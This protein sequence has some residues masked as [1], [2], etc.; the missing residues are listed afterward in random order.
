[1]WEVSAA[2]RERGEPI[3]LPHYEQPPVETLRH[4]LDR[5]AEEVYR[6]LPTDAHRNV[7]RLIFQQL[8]DRDAENREVRRPTPLSELTAV[9]VEAASRTDAPVDAGVVR[10]V[11]AAF[12]GKGRAF[13]VINAQQDVDI[14]HESFIRRWTRLR[15]WVLRESRSRRVYL[16]LADVAASWREGQASLYRGPELTEA[17]RWWKQETPTQ[18]WANRYD[19]RF[20]VARRFLEKSQRWR[21][22][23][24]AVVFGNVAV[25]L[26]GA[27]VIA[28]LMAKGRAEAQRAE[29]EAKRAEAAALQ[30]RNDTDVANRRLA[31][32]NQLIEQA[33]TLQKEGKSQQAAAL[34]QEAQQVQSTANTSTLTASE[35]S[36]L[37][38]LRRQ[39]ATWLKTEADLRGQ[40][41][42][43]R[44][45][46]NAAPPVAAAPNPEAAPPSKA[47][48]AGSER[49]ELEKLR[50]ARA[51]W[52]RETAQL[53]QQLTSANDRAKILQQSE[54]SL[55]RV[56]ENLQARLDKGD[57]GEGR[58]SDRTAIEQ[59]LRDFEAAYRNRDVNA[60]VKLMPS[61]KRADLTRTFSQVRAYEMKIRDAQIAVNGDTAL[62]TGIREISIDGSARFAPQP[63]PIVLRLKRSAGTWIIDSVDEKP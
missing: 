4:A 48:L 30:A 40:L 63:T 45:A 46:Q 55:R 11:I 38:R 41:T 37:Q 44:T 14:S 50:T 22:L 20:A 9:A 3:D 35:L 29:A 43:A 27:W 24:R 17:R 33:L 34:V 47:G 8:T 23:R 19:S 39:E 57:P 60:V 52:E 16:K 6:E 51:N 53:Q 59:V 28:A 32:A 15:E 26:V 1:M 7:A 62:V 10:D 54:S 36:D 56:N 12:S 21:L 18:S 61:A 31:Q 42:A 13:V 49:D 58:A 5:H 25:L 2:A